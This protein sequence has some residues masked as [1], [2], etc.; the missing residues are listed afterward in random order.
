MCDCGPEFEC[1]TCHW[2]MCCSG[3]ATG[4]SEPL[5][6]PT[7]AQKDLCRDDDAPR[8]DFERETYQ[9]ADEEPADG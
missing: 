7:N 8:R 6:E 4:C 1:L 2:C 9:Q 5:K 3:H